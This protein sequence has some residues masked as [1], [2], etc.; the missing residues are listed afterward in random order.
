MTG[1]AAENAA[2]TATEQVARAIASGGARVT[3]NGGPGGAVL[4]GD[5]RSLT[6]RD[7]AEIRSRVRHG[8]KIR[9]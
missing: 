4:R 1:D 6:S 3:E 8:E 2:R 9:F 5:P 7:L